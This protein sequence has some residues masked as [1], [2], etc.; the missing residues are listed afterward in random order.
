MLVEIAVMCAAYQLPWARVKPLHRPVASIGGRAM[1]LLMLQSQAPLRQASTPGVH[2]M[3][4]VLRIFTVHG[5]AASQ[6]RTACP[7]CT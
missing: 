6:F 3:S 4:H 5:R 2:H 1:S 7:C